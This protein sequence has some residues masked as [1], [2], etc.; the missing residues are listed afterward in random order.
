MLDVFVRF[1][2]YLLNQ[3]QESLQDGT[4]RVG[5]FEL[6]VFTADKITFALTDASPDVLY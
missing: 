5:S 3:L 4:V 2:Q 1:S 6:I